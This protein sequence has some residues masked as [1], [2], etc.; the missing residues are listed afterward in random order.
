MERQEVKE[1]FSLIYEVL[2]VVKIKNGSKVGLIL[3]DLGGRFDLTV[4]N[5]DANGDFK[6]LK[7]RNFDRT[8]MFD[9]TFYRKATFP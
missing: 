7:R 9:K 5:V 6:K 3:I 1:Q 4:F 8:A 2:M